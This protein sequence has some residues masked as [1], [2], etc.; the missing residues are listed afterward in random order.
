M[1]PIQWSSSVEIPNAQKLLDQVQ[2]HGGSI[3]EYQ[4][5]F[6]LLL[7]S[8]SSPQYVWMRAG[9]SRFRAGL[10]HSIF[11]LITGWWSLPGI[12]WTPACV[13]YNSFGG[14]DVTRLLQLAHRPAPQPVSS[15]PPP[16]PISSRPPT[17]PPPLPVSQETTL[18][19]ADVIELNRVLQSRD[20]FRSYKLRCGLGLCALIYCAGYLFSK[21][22]PGSP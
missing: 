1:I 16:L 7:F 19:E 6:S 11:T 8:Q 21:L 14:T 20:S 9:G 22:H 13:L 3:I 10:E 5:V 2:R 15:S 4:R 17:L 18:S 12:F